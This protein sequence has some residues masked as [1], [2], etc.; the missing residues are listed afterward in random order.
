LSDEELVTLG[1]GLSSHVRVVAVTCG[2]SGGYFFAAGAAYVGRIDPHA[3]QVKSTVGCGDVLTA[4]LISAQLRGED[5]GASCRF[6]LAAAAAAA[7]H[8]APG[9]FDPRSAARILDRTSVVPV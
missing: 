2:P 5:F 9:V 7:A 8:L 3:T 1:R 6:A 4:A